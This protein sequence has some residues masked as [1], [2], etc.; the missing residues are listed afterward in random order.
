MRRRRFAPCPAQ[1]RATSSRLLQHP[2]LFSSSAA[3]FDL[4]GW[5]QTT[6]AL[7]GESS[8]TALTLTPSPPQS[9][10]EGGQSQAVPM[11]DETPTALARGE[12]SDMSTTPLDLG[13]RTCPWK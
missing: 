2:L 4:R 13:G 5:V 1:A 9:A 11:A 7:L 12:S 8:R 10:S 6:L 3:S